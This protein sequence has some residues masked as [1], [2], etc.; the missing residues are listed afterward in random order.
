MSLVSYLRRTVQKLICADRI[1][2]VNSTY[3]TDLDKALA[4][5]LIQYRYFIKEEASPAATCWR[6]LSGMD[7]K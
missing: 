2:A 5:E 7:L 4:D 6:F 1:Y 3:P